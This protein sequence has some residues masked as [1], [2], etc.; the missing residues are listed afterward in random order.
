MAFPKHQCKDKCLYP[1]Q[2]STSVSS[3]ALIKYPNINKQYY[4]NSKV[5]CKASLLKCTI[6]PRE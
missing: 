1:I 3:P 5:K 6:L 4:D 2:L